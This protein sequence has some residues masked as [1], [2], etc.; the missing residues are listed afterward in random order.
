MLSDSTILQIIE[1]WRIKTKEKLLPRSALNKILLDS[2]K[3]EIIDLIGIR[4]CGK[5]STLFLL[6]QALNLQ[7]E[8]FIYINFEDPSF[9]NNY[10]ED[11]LERIWNVYMIHYDP[12]N[13]PYLFFDEIQYVQGWEQ[14]V[15]KYN[16]LGKAHI[17]VTGSSS[18]LLSREFGSKLTG[19]HKS[20]I[21]T[22]LCFR[23]FLLFIN[24]KVPENMIDATKNKL[25][26][27]KA[28][29]DYLEFGGFPQI[30]LNKDFELLKNYFE[31][32][33]YKDI[34]VR[35]SIRDVNGLRAL[36]KYCLT[37][38]GT[39]M[40]YNSIKKA[41]G[42]SIDSVQAYMSYLEEAFMIFQI[43]L[44]SYSIKK[45]E[46]NPKKI[47][48]ADTGLRNSVC[49]SHSK[50]QGKL[51]ETLVFLELKKHTQEL[52]YWQG[53]QEIDFVYKKEKITAINVSFT[54]NLPEREIL[55]LEE[56]EKEFKG[57]INKILITKDLEKVE[58]NIL[59][60]PL[61]KFLLFPEKY[62]K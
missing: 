26:Y 56:F 44:F 61:W 47:Y 2:S 55:G 17:F 27:Q 23:E 30:V 60:I 1:D 39:K 57:K 28:L 33:I 34:V 3:K 14:W 9:I 49:F 19:R 8:D 53:K 38:T 29:N 59:F 16:E 62:L 45:Q 35:H 41:L 52:F 51:A 25:M 7:D 6:I 40:S 15:R 21:I 36:A 24:V 46:Y 54:N 42:I 50:D 4:R 22:P 48:A 43:P 10:S 12:K 5:S 37:N 20:H 18:V 31:D 11:L 58:N 32:I 13:K